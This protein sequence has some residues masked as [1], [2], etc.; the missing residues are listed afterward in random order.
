MNTIIFFFSTIFHTPSFCFT[1]ALVLFP[2]FISEVLLLLLLFILLLFR[3]GRVLALIKAVLF[4]VQKE[5]MLCSSS[6]M[7]RRSS[8]SLHFSI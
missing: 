8:P 5:A 6:A 3:E 1:E 4:A 2:V 7:R